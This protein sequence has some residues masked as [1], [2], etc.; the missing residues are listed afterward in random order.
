MNRNMIVGTIV[1]IVLIIGAAGVFLIQHERATLKQLEN[2]VTEAEKLL[3]L[4]NNQSQVTG[5]QQPAQKGHVHE[6]GTFHEGEHHAPLETPPPD[7]TPTQVQIPEGITDPDVKEAW[8]RLDYISKNRHKW[9]NFSPRTL[10]LMDELTPLPEL[11]SSEEGCGE[12]I[13]FVL[14]ELS[15]LRDPRSAELLVSYQMDSGVRG[16]PP[17]E[18]L[19]AMGPAAVPA[20]IARL[21]DLSGEDLL[22]DPLHLLPKIMAAHRTELGGIVKYIIIPKNRGNCCSCCARRC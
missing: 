5:A 1:L 8:E 22:Y 20:L 16:R 15:K 7:W 2:D 17:N 12:D 19:V 4:R 21:D 11:G 6:D 10:E 13:I 9:G 18:A 3:K 14:D